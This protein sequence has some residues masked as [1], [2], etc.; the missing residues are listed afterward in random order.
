VIVSVD[1]ARLAEA[2]RLE[3]GQHPHRSPE[4]RA[5]AALYYALTDT[6]TIA[7]ARRALASFATPEVERAAVELL[8]R[9]AAE[10]A[11]T[12]DTTTERTSP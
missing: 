4:R 11:R 1:P 2:A 7:A 5:A 12:D 10:L 3:A 6:G 8:H 9:L